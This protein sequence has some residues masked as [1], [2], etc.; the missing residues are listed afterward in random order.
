MLECS[1]LVAH[2]GFTSKHLKNTF[3][4]LN[5]VVQ[6]TFITIYGGKLMA[7]RTTLEKLV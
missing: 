3:E 4:A 6:L 7:L 2:T 5:A 1:K